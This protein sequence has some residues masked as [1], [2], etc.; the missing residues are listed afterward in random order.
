MRLTGQV[1][2]ATA[3]R[4]GTG[5]VFTVNAMDVQPTRLSSELQH[6]WVYYQVQAKSTGSTVWQTVASKGVGA[7]LT[8]WVA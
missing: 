2:L 3:W 5:Y 1:P 7:D 8:Q 6:V 4:L